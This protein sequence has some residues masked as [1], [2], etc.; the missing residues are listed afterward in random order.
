MYIGTEITRG[1]GYNPQPEFSVVSDDTERLKEFFSQRFSEVCN[2]IP[3][4]E[5]TT[6]HNAWRAVFSYKVGTETI[7]V[8][9]SIREIG[10]IK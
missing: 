2:N 7:E 8:L 5:N 10:F 3:W 9:I 6:H 4:K 1:C